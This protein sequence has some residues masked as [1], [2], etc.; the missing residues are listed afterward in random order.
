MEK[1][2]AKLPVQEKIEKKTKYTDL[3]FARGIL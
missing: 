1:S 3:Q 2:E